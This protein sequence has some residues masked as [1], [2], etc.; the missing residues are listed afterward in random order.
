MMC[1]VYISSVRMRFQRYILLVLLNVWPPLCCQNH[2]QNA[3]TLYFYP[4]LRNHN[5]ILLLEIAV[6][7]LLIMHMMLF[8]T[9]PAMPSLARPAQKIRQIFMS[10]TGNVME[11]QSVVMH[12]LR[13]ITKTPKG[14]S[15]ED[16]SAC[17]QYKSQNLCI[18]SVHRMC[19]L[20]QCYICNMF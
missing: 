6:S 3:S 16:V 19:L 17:N 13:D 5:M 10:H 4:L 18:W 2:E 11:A 8:S 15:T 12:W 14:K 1:Y 7:A 9:W 20:L